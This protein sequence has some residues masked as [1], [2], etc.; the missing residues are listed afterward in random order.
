MKKAFITGAAAG[1][2]LATAKRFRSDGWRVGLCDVDA[3]L[4][5]SLRLQP[6]AR[7]CRFYACDVTDS[8]ALARTMDAF[9]NDGGSG[10][11]V[12]VNNAG[13][14][15]GGAFA[16]QSVDQIRK[17]VDVN[18][19]G[20]SYC[21]RFAFAHLRQRSGCL[22]NMCSA[23]SLHGVPGLAVYSS[24]KHYVKSL[25][26]AL[27]LEWEGSN[28][29]VTAILAP[30]VDTNMLLDVPTGLHAKLGVELTADDIAA[31]IAEAASGSKVHHLVTVQVKVW[32]FA[33][34][35][36]SKPMRARLV[37]YLSSAWLENRT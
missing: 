21:A 24:T 13:V 9:A 8:D 31:L 25:T 12:V 32:D 37:K 27:Q 29:R 2:G 1:I 3:S 11:D 30:F 35:L 7:D 5:E 36:L 18:A 34:R 26:E 22:V 14:L 4:L 23:S 15:C 20:F 17:M 6:W 28:V 33:S 16:E 19:L 10:I